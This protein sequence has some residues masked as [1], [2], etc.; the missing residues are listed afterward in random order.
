MKS[1]RYAAVLVGLSGGGVLVATIITGRAPVERESIWSIAVATVDSPFEL[2][3]KAADLTPSISSADV[4]DVQARFVADPFL[5]RHEDRWTM[6]F[7]VLNEST[8]QGDIGYATSCDGKEWTYQHIVLDEPFHLSYPSVFE[9]DGEFYMVP[10]SQAADSVRLYRATAFPSEWTYERTLISGIDFADPTVI[11]HNGGWFMLIGQPNTHDQLRLFF[12]D[13]LEGPWSE[14]PASPLVERN[15]GIS[16]PAGAVIKVDGKIYRLAQD[17]SW[18]YG[19]AV[20]AFEITQLSKDRYE[21]AE[22]PTTVLTA[23]RNKWNSYGMHHLHAQRTSDGRWIC[24]VDG[25]CKK[26]VWVWNRD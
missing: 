21:E 19:Q 25:H 16:R 6:F 17:C 24:S 12:S 18:R 8:D 20:L 26:L 9:H 2:N 15:A 23:Q 7:E 10:E 3:K 13:G 22:H 14:H 11:Q 1:L 5:I 4:T